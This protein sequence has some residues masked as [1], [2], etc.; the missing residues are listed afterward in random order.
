MAEVWGGIVCVVVSFCPFAPDAP[1]ILIT[2]E[3]FEPTNSI[4]D[5]WT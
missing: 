2:Y 5:L 3:Q 1:L 4:L